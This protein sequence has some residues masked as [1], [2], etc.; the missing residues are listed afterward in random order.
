LI[1]LQKSNTTNRMAENIHY[2]APMSLTE[3]VD[4]LTQIAMSLTKGRDEMVSRLA[5][6]RQLAQDHAEKV[7]DAAARNIE[8]NTG[9][10]IEELSKA[11]AKDLEDRFNL[12]TSKQQVA[13]TSRADAIEKRILAERQ[14]AVTLADVRPELESLVAG[15]IESRR[16]ELS[17]GADNAAQEAVKVA[18]AS[19]DVPFSRMVF[20]GQWDP[21]ATYSVND[22][23]YY[24]GG[25]FVAL[26]STQQ[27]PAAVSPDWQQIAAAGARGPA[28]NDG[29]AD[30][31]IAAKDAAEA[32]AAQT[33][34]DRIAVEA[35]AAIVIPSTDLNAARNA[36]APRQW[37]ML[38]NS[39]TVSGRTISINSADG[40]SFLMSFIPRSNFNWL[41]IGASS[42]HIRLGLATNL[43]FRIAGPAGNADANNP[44]TTGSLI[45]KLIHA[46]GVYD[47]FAQTIT[48]YINGAP[49]TPVDTAEIGDFT[50]QSELFLGSVTGIS[51][52]S[53]LDFTDFTWWN[54]AIP[55]TTTGGVKGVAERYASG[56]WVP[57][58][59]QGLTGDRA[60]LNLQPQG[61]GRQLIDVSANR[62]HA[63]ATAHPAYTQPAN[64][65]IHK[66]TVANAT[67]SATNTDLAG[68]AIQPA[69]TYIESIR[70][71]RTAGTGAFQI[72]TASAGAQVVASTSAASG[73]AT[74]V[75]LR[76]TT[77]AA[78]VFVNMAANTTYDFIFTFAKI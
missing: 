3:R 52:F 19:M 27:L 28:G 16:V 64:S 33:E 46:V 26:Q 77:T 75:I 53:D 68:G 60:I 25:S 7:I 8:A 48:L 9:K 37:V 49:G 15:A 70:F 43:Q 35:A 20:K 76:D 50:F 62:N 17:K 32:A 22:V 5:G 44:A 58:E 23:V 45:G 11:A 56:V 73:V 12:L 18:L 74:M 41:R 55:A 40:F 42:P 71:I 61:L 36:A 1:S 38:R 6:I 29:D 24:R 14:R 4:A 57:A 10:S 31:A 78:D 72:G 13:L 2:T 67:G 39:N 65:C 69:N 63:L 21:S 34:A 66:I 30:E 59:E 47:A 54:F 51:A